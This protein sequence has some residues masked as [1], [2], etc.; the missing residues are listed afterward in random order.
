MQPRRSFG[1][2]AFGFIYGKL[3]RFDAP[4]QQRTEV[5]VRLNFELRVKVQP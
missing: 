1:I 5:K 4:L 3:P 2:I